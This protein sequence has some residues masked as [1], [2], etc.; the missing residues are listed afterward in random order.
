MLL[1]RYGMKTAQ[2]GARQR[3]KGVPNNWARYD[4]LAP[5]VAAP[6]AISV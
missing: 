1:A 5:A 3:A 2:H 6:M 4:L